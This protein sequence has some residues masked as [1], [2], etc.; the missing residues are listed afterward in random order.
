MSKFEW[1]LANGKKVQNQVKVV[2]KSV[3]IVIGEKEKGT[4]TQ[5]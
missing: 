2:S 3:E 4:K 1:I 5:S